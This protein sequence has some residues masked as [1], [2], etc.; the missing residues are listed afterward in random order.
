MA[1]T[2]NADS[3][4]IS[5]SAGL[6]SSADSSGVLQLQTNGT[7]AVTVNASANVGIG[8]AS[9]ATKLDVVGVINGG[10]VQTSGSAAGSFGASKW[11][12]QA[13]DAN[14]VRAY[15]CGGDA[16]T[17]GNFEQ[18]VA[19]STG[20]PVL[21][22]RWSAN[23]NVTLRNIGVGS[24]TPTTSGTGITFPATQ[25]ASTDANTLDD[26]E[27]GAWSP[28]ITN[29]T[30]N[31]T[32]YFFNVGRYTKIGRSVSIT[33]QIS[34]F[35]IGITSGNIFITGLP[36]PMA[37]TE[38]TTQTS[39]AVLGFKYSPTTGTVVYKIEAATPTNL[40]PYFPATFPTQLTY[41]DLGTGGQW[42]LN[43]TY[44]TT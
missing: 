3:G 32:S 43:T 4:A 22:Q 31:V 26:Y 9:P 6:K 16:S 10:T 21:A 7:T 5:G 2:L 12:V 11:F 44:F 30:T 18:Y 37:Q 29:G 1:S 20:S 17:S 36:F 35:T 23:G 24:T 34:V 41:A 25:S 40:D 8:T 15:V 42:Y 14:T 13:E 28:I 27:E 33:M 19:T 39:N 38:I